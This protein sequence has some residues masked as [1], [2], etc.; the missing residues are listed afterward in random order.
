MVLPLFEGLG[1][2]FGRQV[3]GAQP[4]RI[5]VDDDGAQAAA[6]RL[7]G[8]RA[9]QAGQLRPDAEQH[10]VGQF[11]DAAR[12]AGERHVGDR[13]HAGVQ[14]HDERRDGAGREEG[15]GPVGVDG[16]FG[17][18]LGHVGAGMEVEL[19]Q[20]DVLDVLG[21]DVVD[22]VHEQ[23]G[24]FVVVGDEPFHLGGVHAA[25]GLGDVDD[26][27]LRSGKTSVRI[28]ID[29]EHAAQDRS[30]SRRP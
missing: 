3:V 23:E 11:V 2:L 9:G 5:E 13:H 14:R 25:V 29:A 1:D 6:E 21:F 24:V 17:H 7:R 26:R 4:L 20:G 16:G 30:P 10:Q 19:D 18:G 8:R 22:A 12:L 15:L 27:L 28:W